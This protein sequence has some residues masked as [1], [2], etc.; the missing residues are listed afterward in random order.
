MPALPNT[1]LRRPLRAGWMFVGSLAILA[2]VLSAVLVTAIRQRGQYVRE[3]SARQIAVARV[4]EQDVSRTFDLVEDAIEYMTLRIRETNAGD[5]KGVDAMQ[6]VQHVG[7][8]HLLHRAPFLRSLTIVDRDGVVLS[9]TDPELPGRRLLRQAAFA[10]DVMRQGDSG[11]AIGKPQA[12]RDVGSSALAGAAPDDSGRYFIPIMRSVATRDG[13]YV[14]LLAAMNP[15]F[16]MRP[17]EETSQLGGFQTSLATLD[18][19]VLVSRG[20]TALTP[21]TSMRNTAAF[22]ASALDATSGQYNGRGVSSTEAVGAYAVSPTFPL[23][24]VVELSRDQLTEGLLIERRMPLVVGSISFLLLGALAFV[25]WWGLRRGEMA[26]RVLQATTARALASEQ[27]NRAIQAAAPDAVISFDGDFRIVEWNAAS[28]ALSGWLRGEVIGRNVIELIVPEQTRPTVTELLRRAGKERH[29]PQLGGRTA[30]FI[31]RADGIQIPVECGLSVTLVGGETTYSMHLRDTRAE[32]DAAEA[33]RTSERKQRRVLD[34]LHGIV[35]QADCTGVVTYL[36]L[37]WQRA[38]RFG[39]EETLGHELA[40]LVV[41]DDSAKVERFFAALPVSSGDLAPLPSIEVSLRTAEGSVRLVQIVAQPL[42][43]AD[44]KVVGVAGTLDDVTD[45]RAAE[46]R[47]R[48]QLRFS[49]ELIETI[50]VPVSVRGTSHEFVAVNRAWEQFFSKQRDEVLGRLPTEVFPGAQAMQLMGPDDD[51][52]LR[53]GG[54]RQFELERSA[55]DG[56]T[57]TTLNYRSSFVREDGSIGGIITAFIDI[58]EQKKVEQAIRQAKEQAEVA[59]AAKN[60]FLATVSHEL[61]TPLNGIIGMSG[62]ILESELTAD[63]RDSL[64]VVKTS[65]DTLLHIIDDVRDVARIEAGEIQ[66]ERL[67]FD[68]RSA[69]VSVVRMLAVPAHAKGI[70]I[71]SFVGPDVPHTVEGDL[72]RLRQVLLHLVGNAVQFTP[73]GEVLLSILPCPN[74]LEFAVRDTGIGMTD[75]VRDQIQKL[76]SGRSDPRERVQVGGALGISVSGRLIRFMGGTDV[77]VQSSPGGSTIRFVLPFDLKGRPVFKPTQF[78][79]NALAYVPAES[80]RDALA[81]MLSLRGLK[82]RTAGDAATAMAMTDA[83][84]PDIAFVDT[85]WEEND[86][87]AAAEKLQAADPTLPIFMLLP[88]TGPAADAAL[89]RQHSLAGYVR[90][91]VFPADLERALSAVL[92]VRRG[93]E[94]QPAFVAPASEAKPAQS[95]R[96]SNILVAEDNA[97]NQA[98]IRRLLQ[99]AGHR[100][101][102]VTDGVAA[103]DAVA[104]ERFDLVLMDVQMPHMDGLEATRRI[105]AQENEGGAARTPIIA[106]TAHA[107][108]GDRELCLE[109]GMD[110]YLSKPIN[111]SVLQ[112]VMQ[113]HLPE[114]AGEEIPARS[115]EEP[116]MEESQ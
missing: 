83:D 33:L 108:G 64:E 43:D 91:P 18:G 49:R 35:F 56:S 69:A 50:P 44:G 100:V 67:A 24:V 59:N 88:V 19:T 53:S 4:L 95:R 46:I 14:E 115:G 32:R 93:T 109:A 77:A 7:L 29:A 62:L 86:G 99:N 111:A 66:L 98:L 82:V 5:L 27:R 39:V 90:K 36:N 110:G 52:L 106:L 61:R 54:H 112:R 8:F 102:I 30:M 101:S 40:G 51:D 25:N 79:G 92:D 34:S 80:T 15:D 48:D 41:R 11:L 37:A 70:D 87:F 28:E 3:V 81:A 103:V 74:G 113:Q 97:V 72:H 89:V 76:F 58:S 65:A 10:A 85:G 116:R 31:V 107:F 47:L 12:G 71:V 57:R 96:K 1:G 13:K 21:G 38:T 45:K 114:D 104:R 55:S 60:D 42:T 63:Q 78:R 22:G 20:P 84:P 73:S 16:L 94:P 105:R 9:S 75:V 26:E 2:A 17:F 68:V 6:V 23:A